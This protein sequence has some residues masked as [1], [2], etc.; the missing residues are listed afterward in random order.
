MKTFKFPFNQSGGYIYDSTGLLCARVFD[1]VLKP[2][3]INEMADIIT[4][5]LNKRW[6]ERNIELLLKYHGLDYPSQY[7]E[8][9]ANTYSAS[10]DK[11]QQLFTAMPM[12][13]KK[14]FIGFV[15]ESK[16]LPNSAFNFFL[17][18]L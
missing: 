3:E 14:V 4:D 2:Y 9:T 6:N 18:L 8:L 13:T 7:M 1:D 15:A 5:A 16:D 11:A 10:P 12:Q 17:N